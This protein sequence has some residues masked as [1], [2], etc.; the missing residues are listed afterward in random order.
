MAGCGRRSGGHVVRGRPRGVPRA[1][2][3]RREQTGSR[4]PAGND[5][6]PAPSVLPNSLGMP[7]CMNGRPPVSIQGHRPAWRRE[8]DRRPLNFHRVERPRPRRATHIQVPGAEGALLRELASR[9]AVDAAAQLVVTCEM[10]RRPATQVRMYMWCQ[11]GAPFDGGGRR[12]GPCAK[13]LR[14]PLG[15]AGRG[16]S[17]LTPNCYYCCG[18]TWA[19]APLGHALLRTTANPSISLSREPSAWSTPATNSHTHHSPPGVLDLRHAHLQPLRP[20]P[21][22]PRCGRAALAAR[23]RPWPDARTAWPAGAGAQAAG[24]RAGARDRAA[25]GKVNGGT[26]AQM[27]HTCGGRR[28]PRAAAVGGLPLHP[29][30]THRRRGPNHPRRAAFARAPQ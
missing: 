22:L 26:H 5:K 23:G 6:G 28:P 19:A 13:R 18:F 14:A 8:M 25:R 29:L 1:G 3:G 10:C 17:G 12:A 15:S 11:R 9:C 7:P 27:L 24:R 16:P 4:Q 2:R 20:P 30:S 21:P